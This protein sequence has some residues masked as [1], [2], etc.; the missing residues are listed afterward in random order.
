M[1][2]PKQQEIAPSITSIIR[3]ISDDK[4]LVL[5]DS[6]AASFSYNDRSIPPKRN[7]SK[8]KAILF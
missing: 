5:F 8:Y 2:N 7:E 3:K 4:A 1:E 6:I